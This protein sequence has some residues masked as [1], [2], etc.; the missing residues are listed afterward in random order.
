[1]SKGM[2]NKKNKVPK[3]NEEEYAAYIALLKEEEKTPT[4]LGETREIPNFT[5]SENKTE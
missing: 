5:A 1:M 2:K 3:I 4:E